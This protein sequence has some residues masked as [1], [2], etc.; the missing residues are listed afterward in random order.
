MDR[1]GWQAAVHGVYMDSCLIS[2]L[3]Q[4]PWAQGPCLVVRICVYIPSPVVQ[5]GLTHCMQES[6]LSQ[7]ST[8][9][10]L[11]CELLNL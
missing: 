11:D 10:F 8:G 3:S 4:S 7:P 5:S 1:G 6:Q 2:Q 9:T